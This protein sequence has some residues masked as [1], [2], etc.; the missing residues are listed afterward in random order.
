MK[1]YVFTNTL[2]IEGA[3]NFEHTEEI[4]NYEDAIDYYRSTFK[5]QAELVVDCG[6][7][8]TI[9]MYTKENG[10][11]RV[12]KRNTIATTLSLK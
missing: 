1:Y 7:D 11:I 9:M 4:S 2:N 8:H 6:G 10:N 3:E 5:N 12:L